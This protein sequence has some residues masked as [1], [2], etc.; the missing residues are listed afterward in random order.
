MYYPQEHS[1]TAGG[2]INASGARPDR[3]GLLG[4]SKL[5]EPMDGSF[6]GVGR[7]SRVDREGKTSVAR[8]CPPTVH[9]EQSSCRDIASLL[10]W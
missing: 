1:I 8:H 2:N 4:D 3:S 5:H 9:N 7:H 10:A 6:P